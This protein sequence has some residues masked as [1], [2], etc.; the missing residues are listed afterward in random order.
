MKL[1]HRQAQAWILLG[2]HTLEAHTRKQRIL[3]RSNAEA[4]LYAAAFG[5]SESKGIA[6]LLKDLGDEMKPVLAIDAKTTE[7]VDWNTLTWHT[8]GC[9]M[10]SDP[11]GLRARRV[12]SEENVADVGTKTLR[13]AVIA[14]H[15]LAPSVQIAR[16]GDV[17]GHRFD[18]HDRDGWQDSQCA[19]HRR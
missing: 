17:L 1:E 3:A 6:S 14:K 15:C 11:R 19:E 13:K 8:C 9:K 4:E 2:S 7:L 16:R 10:K 12:K 5:A 18:P